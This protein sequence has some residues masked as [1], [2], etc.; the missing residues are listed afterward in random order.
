P[1]TT[2]A[3]VTRGATTLSNSS[4][5]A[6]MAYSNAINPVELP[7]GR[8]ML[9]TKPPPTGS[10]TPAN[11]IGTTRVACCNVATPTLVSVNTTSGASATNSV[12]YLRRRSTSPAAQ[13]VSIRTVSPSVQP[14]S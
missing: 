7:P 9:S 11:T 8:A 3:P 2:A 5:F 1:A 10:I 4:H 13:R 12:V 14:H 6:P